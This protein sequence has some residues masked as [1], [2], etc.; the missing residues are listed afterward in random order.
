MIRELQTES[1]SNHTARYSEEELGDLLLRSM[2]FYERLA[3]LRDA[4][5]MPSEEKH[6]QLLTTWSANLGIPPSEVWER[7]SEHNEFDAQAMRAVLDTTNLDPDK[8]ETT[9]WL[10]FYK[11]VLD[12]LGTIHLDA[13]FFEAHRSHAFLHALIPFVETAKKGLAKRVAGLG[14]SIDH[15]PLEGCLRFLNYS[16]SN[17]ASK[18][19]L[20]EFRAFKAERESAFSRFI[21]A[22][23]N[24]APDRLY[25]QFIESVLTEEWHTVFGEYPVL[26]R[27]LCTSCL[28][29][30]HT[31]SALIERFRSD[32]AE[33]AAKFNND[34]PLGALKEFRF[35][36]S[37]KHNGGF[38]TVVLEFDSGKK[39][40]YKPKSLGTDRIVKEV[41]QWINSRSDLLEL[42]TVAVIDKGDYGW[43]EFIEHEGCND[44]AAMSEFY[45]RAGYWLALV[46]MFEG[47]DYHHENM[48]AHGAYP[49]LID[50]ETIFNP[51][52]ES[53]VNKDGVLSAMAL[54]SDSVLYSVIRTG[55]LPNW[56]IGAKGAKK[57]TSGFGGRAVEGNDQVKTRRWTGL[58]TDDIKLTWV[59][60]PVEDMGNQPYV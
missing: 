35:G 59:E 22:E 32:E 53:E 17:L 30:M 54:A 57:D 52:K 31:V 11:A 37:D 9:P 56:N 2:H 25:R 49:Y 16:L 50:T 40:V 42:R 8:L 48:I 41:A 55:M 18:A 43:Q 1:N 5:A 39:I 33:L 4:A 28:H 14:T 58:A 46:Y 20:L 60:R 23:E 3:L 13:S 36:M 34:H 38:T 24:A 45:Q 51:F 7:R 44:K 12:G 29:W 26:L 27:Q 47:Y 10:E 15:F 19:L 6:E 21:S